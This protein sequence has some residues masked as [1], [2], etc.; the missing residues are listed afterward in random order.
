MNEVGLY[1]QVV[2]DELGRVRVVRQDAAN[3]GSG[4]VHLIDLVLS[5]PPVDGMLVH[6][7]EF[8]SL[9]DQGFYSIGLQP[10]ADR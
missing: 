3:P 5:E 1:R 10:A 2:V 6:E 7:I 8:R 4:N 9:G